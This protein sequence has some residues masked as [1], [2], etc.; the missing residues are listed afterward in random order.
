MCCGLLQSVAVCCSLLQSVA[1]HISI[2]NS[3]F[4]TQS[5]KATELQIDCFPVTIV[6]QYFIL[7]HGVLQCELA[8]QTQMTTE[9]TVQ[10]I[11]IYIYMCS[12]SCCATDRWPCCTG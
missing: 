12:R 6:L 2:L 3:E 9:L 8:T 11:Y 7:C 1:A 5:Q 4:A 10:Y